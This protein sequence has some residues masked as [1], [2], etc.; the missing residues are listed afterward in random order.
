MPLLSQDWA[1]SLE[2]KPGRLLEQREERKAT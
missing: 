2:F 1:D